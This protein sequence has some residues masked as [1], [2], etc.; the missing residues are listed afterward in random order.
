MVP[1]PWKYVNS[2]IC[3]G[4]GICCKEYEVV[5][6][7]EEWLNIIRAY[8]VNTTKAGLNKFFLGKKND[9]T[10]LFL[11]RSSFGWLCSLQNMKPAA[12]KI[13]PFK[14]AARP[15]YGRPKESSY[16]YRGKKV[17]VYVDPFCPQIRWGQPGSKMVYNI[18]PEFIEIALGSR[19]KQMY[20][21]SSVLDGTALARAYLTN[22]KDRYRLI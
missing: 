14:I 2:W 19:R 20:S 3:N 10:C 17:Y 5:L 15:L 21:T 12:C 4:C 6:K 8:G 22:T 1:V 11:C 7:F 9:G 18:I 13:W 16:D